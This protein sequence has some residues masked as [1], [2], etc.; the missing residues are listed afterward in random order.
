MFGREGTIVPTGDVFQGNMKWAKWE[1]YLEIEVYPGYGVEE[2]GFEYYGGGK[3]TVDISMRN[4]WGKEEVAVEYGS[5]GVKTTLVMFGKTGVKR[6]D[7]NGKGGQVVVE[8][9]ESLFG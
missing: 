9:F 2:S 1:S 6:F 7:L 3:G 8:K 4:G 5:V